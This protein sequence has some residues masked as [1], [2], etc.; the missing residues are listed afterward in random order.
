MRTH[1]VVVVGAGLAGMRAAIAAHEAGVDVALVTKVHPVRSH[2]GAAQGGINAALGNETEDNPDNHTFDTVKGADYIGDQDAIETLCHRAPE[3]IYKLEH[4]GA[5]FS[6]QE[7]TGKIAQRPFGG[8]GFPRTCYAADLTGLVILH[9]LYTVCVKYDIP[10]YEEWFVT[11][12]VTDSS[13]NCTGV[14]AYDM[15]HGTIE[16]IGAKS[17]V[18]A[19]G[20][21][22]RVYRPSTNAHASTG[23]GMSL[24]LRAGVPLKDMEF[25]QFHPT[26]LKSN[27]VLVTEGARGEGGYLLNKDGERFM[28]KYAPNKLELASRDV[29]S[30]AEATEINEGRG[31][32]GCVLID[33]RHLGRDRIMERLPQIRELAIAFAGVDPID[34]PIPI[35]PGAH[36]HMG[37]VHVDSWGAAPH[38]PGL[39]AAGECACVSVH[40]ANRLGGN[41]LLEA[42]VFG[43]RTGEAAARHVQEAYNGKGP[44][45]PGDAAAQFEAK[46]RAL[47]ERDKGPR[48]AEIRDELAD[49]MQEKVGVF[50]TG[51][52]LEEARQTVHALREKF[53][54][55]VVDDKGQTFNQ[56]LITTLETGYLLDLAEC[57]V[58]G[59]VARTESRGAHSRLDF[60]ERDDETWMKHT[61]SYLEDDE[62]RLD[63][64]EVTVTKFQPQVRSY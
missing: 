64:S 8:A 56:D 55:V 49:T 44:E 33:L 31:V 24:A 27:G 30:R 45:V 38:M 3:E 54:G 18:L 61:L 15:I 23:D 58:T 62:I 26:T 21:A 5:V 59:A 51:A 6:R 1:D 22:G 4:W 11:E 25:M 32:D 48:Q 19:T 40:G 42:V 2:S 28:S 9:T 36:Y 12:L 20:G 14:V 41:S 7:G 52:Q 57:M 47:L 17:V 35:R 10:T 37:G 60:P 34:E 39:F 63:Y 43:A 13:G 53:K 16:T 50:R 46:L 29:V